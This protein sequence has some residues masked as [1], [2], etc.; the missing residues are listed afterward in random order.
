VRID[1]GLRNDV[2]DGTLY[3]GARVVEAVGVILAQAFRGTYPIEPDI[4]HRFAIPEIP[5]R[6]N[7]HEEVV[8]TVEP[9]LRHLESKLDKVDGGPS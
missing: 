9:L 8:A 5:E 4:M 3:S 6:L 2:G 7:G 1:A